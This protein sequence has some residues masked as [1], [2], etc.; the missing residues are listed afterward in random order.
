MRGLIIAITCALSISFSYADC[1]D[2]LQW[3]ENRESEAALNWVKAHNAES[4]ARIEALPSFAPLLEDFKKIYSASD[5]L[6]EL[7]FFG[8]DFLNFWTDE[9][10]VRGIL[11]IAP[12]ADVL[13][14]KA[15]WETILDIDAINR[16]EGKSW[17]FGGLSCVDRETRERCLVSLSDAGSDAVVIRE[18]DF[19]KRTFVADG[20]DIP[21]AKTE[22]SWVDADTILIA[23]DFGE[24][25]LTKSGYARQLR[26]LKRGQA[27]SEAKLVS[28]VSVED[29]GISSYRLKSGDKYI[30][31]VRKS[32][33]FYTSS[34]LLLDENYTEKALPLP[35]GA[36][37]AGYFKG[38]ILFTTRFAM[39]A[40]GRMAR[41]GSLIAFKPEEI[42]NPQ[43][44]VVFEPKEAEAYD[45]IAITKKRLY[46]S[47]LENVN[48]KLR[49]IDLTEGSWTGQEISVPEGS[50]IGL[51]ADSE[52]NLL[53]IT[54]A[55]FTKAPVESSLTD[56]ASSPAFF[57]KSPERFDASD[58]VTE[59][60]FATGKDGTR[61]PYYLVYKKSYSGSGPRPTLL[62]AYG[63][64][65]V[66]YTPSYAATIGK[67]WLERGGVYALANIRGGG[68]YGPEWH[69]SALLENRQNAFDDLASVAESL[70]GQ[71]V[72]TPNK[73]AIMGGSNGG[74]LVS[75]V[76]LQRPDLFAAVLCQVPLADML[77]YHLFPA[78]D[79]W[80]AEYGDPENATHRSWLEKY[81]PYQNARAGVKYPEIFFTT[82]TADDRVHPLHARKLAAKLEELGNPIEYYENLEGGHGGAADI[83]QRARYWA[84]QYAFLIDRLRLK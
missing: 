39:Q 65:M 12:Q 15:Q 43:F 10:H 47:Y 61:I 9:K 22:Y 73:L 44:Q 26:L 32:K 48:G 84:L 60:K 27:L 42:D 16:A 50:G 69:K 33:D 21:K 4:L 37:L 66:S 58:I 24:G 83:E 35:P 55:S 3:L 45:G 34:T 54:S 82:S 8:K 18:F 51:D 53:F 2:P 17:V 23:T 74:L 77:R 49:A 75:T 30:N 19:A 29:L 52:S 1:D 70:I 46:L 36:E 72:T 6:P 57:R 38:H 28:E 63:G 25:T 11:R 81:S 67:G 64:F 40:S 41:S 68:E 71:G 80:V 56:E 7:D 31:F 76:A 62:N 13:A 59:Q 14:H 20:F 78:G 5:K 79:S